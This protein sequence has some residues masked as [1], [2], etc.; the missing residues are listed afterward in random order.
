M[1]NVDGWPLYMAPGECRW[2]GWF[3]WVFSLFNQCHGLNCKNW[4]KSWDPVAGCVSGHWVQPRSTSE[5]PLAGRRP[6]LNWFPSPIR[7]DPAPNLIRPVWHLHI[8]TYHQ[9]S[10]EPGH[11]CT[12]HKT[13]K[14]Q[15]SFPSQIHALFMTLPIIL[16]WCEQDYE[17]RFDP[18]QFTNIK[19][20]IQKPLWKR[21]HQ[22]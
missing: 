10:G 8:T 22:L 9:C 3:S 12:G 21:K 1:S 5:A 13:K 2:Q 7:I 14:I 17:S 4:T 11:Q 18:L 16:R 19:I 15:E 6:G 20:C